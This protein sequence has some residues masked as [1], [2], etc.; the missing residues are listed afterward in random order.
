MRRQAIQ[1]VELTFIN[2]SLSTEEQERMK[3]QRLEAIR[4]LEVRRMNELTAQIEEWNYS[5]FQDAKI[6][7]EGRE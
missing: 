2:R 5:D 7:I 6:H 1:L 4:K 3:N